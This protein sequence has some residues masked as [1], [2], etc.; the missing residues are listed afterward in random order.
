MFRNRVIDIDR[1]LMRPESS[2]PRADDRRDGLADRPGG[3][4]E[5]HRRGSLT[6]GCGRF[7]RRPPAS[8][9]R[10]TRRRAATLSPSVRPAWISTQR[11]DDARF[12]CRTSTLPS[13]TTSRRAR[14]RP[15]M[16]VAGTPTPSRRQFAWRAAPIWARE[17]S[18][19]RSGALPVRSL[20]RPPGSRGGRGPRPRPRRPAFSSAAC[21]RRDERASA[22]AR[23]PRDLSLRP[24]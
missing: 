1:K 2:G 21:R 5:A 3:D 19:A 23:R 20:C 17:T 16:R 12:A 4:V 18:Q 24:G 8:P 22:Q 6:V 10:G 14:R 9:D 11:I 15:P 13:R 7:G